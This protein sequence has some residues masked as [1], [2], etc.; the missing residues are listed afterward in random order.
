LDWLILVYVSVFII[1]ASFSVLV[2]Y[3]I[4]TLKATE[5]TLNN[6]AST[7]NDAEK[8]LNG[9]TYEVTELLKKTNKAADQIQQK[10]ASLSKVSESLAEVGNEALEVQNELKSFLQNVAKNINKH[11][12]GISQAVKLG[13]SALSLVKKWRSKNL[14]EE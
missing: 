2:Y 6:I 11:N 13:S 10:T 7:V 9:V 12:D 1:A 5:L 3:V 8:Q 14:K 4:R